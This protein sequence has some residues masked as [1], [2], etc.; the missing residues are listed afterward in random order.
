MRLSLLMLA[1]AGFGHGAP[2]LAQTAEGVAGPEIVAELRL[3]TDRRSDLSIVIPGV[4]V[5][6]E[7]LRL[8]VEGGDGVRAEVEEGTLLRWAGLQVSDALA[9]L[10]AGQEDSTAPFSV[11]ILMAPGAAFDDMW[12]VQYTLTQG[13]IRRVRFVSGEP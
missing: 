8:R 10:T 2:L 7:R 1:A 12:D 4:F 5:L 11:R 9:L 3:Q 6:P 13:G